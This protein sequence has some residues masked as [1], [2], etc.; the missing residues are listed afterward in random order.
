MGL[1]KWHSNY[2]VGIGEIDG[3]HKM[4]IDF[5]TGPEQD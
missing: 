3:R 1:T 4:P 5:I 2:S